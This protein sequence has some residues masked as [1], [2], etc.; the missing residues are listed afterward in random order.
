[1]E[2]VVKICYAVAPMDG[3]DG[4]DGE[5]GEFGVRMVSLE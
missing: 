3:K 4:E 5:D 1:M 2:L